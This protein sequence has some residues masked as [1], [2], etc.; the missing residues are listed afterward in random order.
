MTESIHEKYRRSIGRW[1]CATIVLT[2][3]CF[4]LIIGIAV[5]TILKNNI[6]KKTTAIPCGGSNSV[7][8]VSEAEDPSIFDDLTVT[9]MKGIQ[10]YIYSVAD[11]NLAKPKRAT[12]NSSY[13]FS[14]DYFLPKKAD[15]LKYLDSNGKKPDREGRLVVFRGDLNPAVVEEYIVGP[16]PHPTYHK[17]LVSSA[18]KNPVPYAHRPLGGVEYE[19]MFN[20]LLI[21]I[22]KEIGYILKESYGATFTNC[23]DKCLVFYPSPLSSAIMNKDVRKLWMYVSHGIEYYTLHPL[24]ISFLANTDNTN[25]SKYFIEQIVY[26]DQTFASLRDFINA[27]NSTSIKKSHISFPEYSENLFSTMN[28]RGKPVP[29]QPQRP[30]KSVEPDGKRYSIHHRHVEYLKWSFDFRMSTLIGPQIYDVRFGGERI[31]YEIGLQ[32]I[33]VYYSGYTKP[34]RVPEFVDSGALIGTHAQALVPGADCPESATFVTTK[35]VADMSLNPIILDKSF[36]IF[37]QD[38][39][40]PLRRHLSYSVGEGGFYSGLSDIVLILRT[41]LTIV[42][43]DYIVDFVFHESGALEMRTLST[44]YIFTSFYNG[45]KSPYGFRL[46]ENM[47]ANIHHHLF[48]WKADLDILGTRNR[49]E[50]LDISTENVNNEVNSGI[51]GETYAQ[52][53][54]NRNLKETELQAAYKFNFDRPRYH[55]VHNNKHQTKFGVPRAYR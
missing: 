31:A 14:Y 8:D 34:P 45:M 36:C 55:I 54:F 46:H 15:V 39:G 24:D 52:I 41:A 21:P 9:E 13:I 18:R 2:L 20:H 3:L 53:L 33:A 30:P 6:I 48:H 19:A 49:Y 51:V 22:D 25:P 47:L 38:T 5:V 1:R 7:I 44:G 32:E 23:K 12:V 37:E 26:G 29:D 50:T 27:Y 43:Y 35:Y 10:E 16:L 42:N 11:L 17:L 40:V 4:G 28:R